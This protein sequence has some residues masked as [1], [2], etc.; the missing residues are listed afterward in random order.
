MS[1]SNFFFR[2]QPLFRLMDL[3]YIQCSSDWQENCQFV[4]DYRLLLITGGKGE[5]FIDNHCFP[6]CQ[7][8]IFLLIP[9]MLIEMRTDTDRPLQ[10]YRMTF[11][12]LRE[13]NETESEVS[14]IKLKDDTLFPQYGERSKHLFNEALLVMKHMQDRL[15]GQDEK[16]AYKHFYLFHQLLDILFQE[17]ADGGQKDAAEVI[18][19]TVDYM[20]QHYQE[21]MTRD[22]LATI[23]GM[24]PWH[25][26]RKFKEIT[27]YRPSDMLE[28][29]RI[30]HAKEHL[31]RLD[32]NIREVA[33]RVGYRDE[34]YF[35]RKF[36]QNVG[37]SPTMF[38]ARK[39]EKI[40]ALSYHYAAHLLTLGVIP[41]ATYVERSREDHRRQY[42]DVIPFHLKRDKRMNAD[43]WEHNLQT[44]AGAKPEVILCDELMDNDVRACMQKIAPIISIPWLELNW[45]NHFREISSFIGKKREAELWMSSYDRKAE[46]LRK[47]WKGKFDRDRVCVL[48]IMIG[49]LYVY[50]ARNGGSVLYEDLQLVPAHDTAAIQVCK[51]ITVEEL[52]RYDADLIFIAIDNDI[53]S[54]QNW[55]RLQSS[56]QWLSL[57]AVKRG[58][59]HVIQEIPW[60]EYSPYAHSMVLDE[61]QH[62]L[63]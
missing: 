42:H 17:E 3:E 62:I 47:Q 31:L 63:G 5:V 20:E 51:Q 61:V 18:K 24:S 2:Q 12:A 45:R 41:F 56:A 40:A 23:A 14:F 4:D 13:S 15:S 54:L 26:S 16:I 11:Q 55:N 46:Q 36:K 49:N 28:A 44:L 60:L 21:E 38:M 43:V 7:G 39:R 6:L 9:A 50:S 58:K 1:S 53:V 30:H 52:L 37:L 35:R 34:A 8:K 57:Q 33:H 10:F 59:A 27:G 48:H 25:F 19:Q 29:I 22:T 32:D